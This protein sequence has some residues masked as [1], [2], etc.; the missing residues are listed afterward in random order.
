MRLIW[1]GNLILLV[2]DNDDILKSYTELLQ[3]A[4]YQVEAHYDPRQ[5]LEQFHLNPNAYDAV[6]TDYNMPNMNGLEIISVIR[7]KRPDIKAVLYSG[8]PPKHTPSYITTLSKP[9]RINQL[10]KV[11]AA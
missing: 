4:N 6:I 3:H 10:L 1:E 7:D 2:D 9:A 5:A 8:M 11:L